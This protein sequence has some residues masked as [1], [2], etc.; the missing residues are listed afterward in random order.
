MRLAIARAGLW[1]FGTIV[2]T[3]FVIGDRFKD[4]SVGEAIAT[5]VVIATIVAGIIFFATWSSYEE[6]QQKLKDKEAK[7]TPR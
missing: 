7:D 6:K 1:F 4:V 3:F 2:F 5:L